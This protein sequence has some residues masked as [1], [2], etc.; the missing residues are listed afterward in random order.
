MNILRI[1]SILFL[2]FLFV[3]IPGKAQSTGSISGKLIDGDEGKALEFAAVAL[4][5]NDSSLVEG[6]ITA[7]DGS[8][9]LE[10]TEGNYYLTIQ[11]V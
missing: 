9:S 11:F 1:F 6:S 8:F 7:K 10:V 5:T 4:F 3:Y 2:S